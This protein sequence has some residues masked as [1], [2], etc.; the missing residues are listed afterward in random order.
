[1][2]VAT[3]ALSQF[4]VVDMIRK[5]EKDIKT[6]Q[7]VIADM[8]KNS[9]TVED[10]VARTKALSAMSKSELKALALEL[11]I[12]ITDVKDKKDFLKVLEDHGQK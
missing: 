3:N 12:N 2:G 9:N 4:Q 5:L 10:Q 8:Q 6:L 11:G 7:E 1:M